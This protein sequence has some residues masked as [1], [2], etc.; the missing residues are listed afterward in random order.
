M[1]RY[2]LSI[3]DRTRYIGVC[4]GFVSGEFYKNTIFSGDGVSPIFGMDY[5]GTAQLKAVNV[6]ENIFLKSGAGTVSS[7]GSEIFHIRDNV[8]SGSIENLNAA[9]GTISKD[10]NF[11][12]PGIR[13]PYAY[14]LQAY[15]SALDSAPALPGNTASTDFFGN[16]ANAHQNYGFY[17]GGGEAKP[18]SWVSD[19]DTQSGLSAWDSAG[20]VALVPD[21][22][23][24]LGSSVRIDSGGSISRG[25]DASITSYRFGALIQVNDATL[26]TASKDAPK[27]S[28]GS[29]VMSL[30]SLSKYD[31][32]Y[33]KSLQVIV[34]GEFV[35]ATLDG[36]PVQVD[37]VNE[38]GG[39]V[40]FD[41]GKQTLFV[42]DVYLFPL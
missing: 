31:I 9:I 8:V 30:T 35:N 24:D 7:K 16:P 4:D 19:F 6:S 29:I 37:A 25:F 27:L 42:D 40:V 17:S 41:A 23:V 22:A 13:D 2:N 14:L 36:A 1:F 15:S 11:M 20:T 33:W 3:N 34:N 32:G 28:L 26:G 39:D 12:A 18:P 21:P 38:K 5:A 10:P